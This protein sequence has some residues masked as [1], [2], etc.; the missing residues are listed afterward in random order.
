M[1]HDCVE[2][3]SCV[4]WDLD[5]QICEGCVNGNRWLCPDDDEDYNAD[6][7]LEDEWNFSE[8]PYLSEK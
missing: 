5:E 6:E 8:E 7:F 2:C 4:H 3:E 1:K